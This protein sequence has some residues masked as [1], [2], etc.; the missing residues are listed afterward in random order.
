NFSADYYPFGMQYQQYARTGNPKNNY[1]YN[2]KELQDGLQLY[3][4]GARLYDPM[5]GR[6]GTVDP[7][8]DEFD[9]V[10]PYNYGMN[11]PILMIDPD[12]MAAD[13]ANFLGQLLKE[14]QIWASKPASNYWQGVGFLAAR[15]VYGD[16]GG[17][18]MPHTRG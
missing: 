7:L 1:L 13:T 10:S 3:D 12:G 18:E 16:L 5:I 4:Y 2:G 11:N 8:A 6:W 14:V 15:N 9:N 17:E